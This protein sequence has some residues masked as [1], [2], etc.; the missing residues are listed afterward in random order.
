[1]ELPCGLTNLGNTCYMNATVQCLRS[2]PEL[3][4]A[5]RRYV[6]LFSSQDTFDDH[7]F[8]T[9]PS[10]DNASCRCER[11]RFLCECSLTAALLVFDLPL[12]ILVLC[13]LQEQMHRHSI[14]QQVLA[15]ANPKCVHLSRS[16]A[17]E[18]TGNLYLHRQPCVTCMRPWT[19]PRR[20]FRPLFCCS[21]ST[22]LFRSLQRREI[23]DSIC[24]RW[25]MILNNFF[26]S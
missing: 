21:S 2:V 13:D 26:C 7:C 1:M 5:L 15:V 19:R 25:K 22:W 12:G 6:F 9:V 8:V 17:F 20:A 14:S 18:L 10:W 23:R 24:S 3:K 4:T 16:D 11:H